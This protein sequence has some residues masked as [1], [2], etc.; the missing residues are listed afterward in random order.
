[1]I[2]AGYKKPM[3]KFLNVNLNLTSHIYQ[4]F[5]FPDHLADELARIFNLK[6]KKKGFY[7]SEVDVSEILTAILV[8]SRERV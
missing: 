8:K 2:F 1:M 7:I 6:A 5:I 4:K 3:D